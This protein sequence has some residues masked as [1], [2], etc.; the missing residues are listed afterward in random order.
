MATKKEILAQMKGVCSDVNSYLDVVS[1]EQ[2]NAT[3]CCLKDQIANVIAD[4]TNAPRLFNSNGNPTDI[5]GGGSYTYTL[6]ANTFKNEGDVIHLQYTVLGEEKDPAVYYGL[7]LTI[8]GSPYAGL[9]AL[10]TAETS[11]AV[12]DV[13][14]TLADGFILCSNSIQMSSNYENNSGTGQYPAV[15]DVTTP[16][17]IVITETEA[18]TCT[19]SIKSYAF[20]YYPYQPL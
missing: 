2:F 17:D 16:L 12:I 15:V 8:G 3:I 13:Y 11:V 1:V 6:P 10:D 7:N 20:T 18:G 9:P 4:N 14:M 5:S 19:V